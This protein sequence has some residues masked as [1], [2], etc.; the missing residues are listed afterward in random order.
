MVAS[1]IGGYCRSGEGGRSWWLGD[2][3]LLL[4]RDGMG[5]M[6]CLDQGVEWWT[7]RTYWLE[8]LRKLHDR[9]PWRLFLRDRTP[10]EGNKIGRI[11]SKII[12]DKKKMIEQAEHRPK[13]VQ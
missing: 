12:D 5:L 4:G 11:I 8:F 7:L 3:N 2:G 10:A 9:G 1:R 6:A 13:V